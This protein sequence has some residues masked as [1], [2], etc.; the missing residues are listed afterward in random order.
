M[1][2]YNELPD[3]LCGVSLLRLEVKQQKKNVIY[4]YINGKLPAVLRIYR[5][6]VSVTVFRW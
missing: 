5:Y 3:F 2:G 4:I 1:I 6:I